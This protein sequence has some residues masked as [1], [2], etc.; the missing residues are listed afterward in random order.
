MVRPPKLQASAAL[1]AM[2]EADEARG[3][4]VFE[5]GPVVQLGPPAPPPE[6]FVIERPDWWAEERAR[7]LVGSTPLDPEAGKTRPAPATEDGPATSTAPNLAKV[8]RWRA[9]MMRPA[10]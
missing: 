3:V 4:A 5:P 7:I 8:K 2:L 9:E 6:P 10:R 1:S